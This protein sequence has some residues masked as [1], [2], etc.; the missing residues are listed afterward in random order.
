MTS[1][2]RDAPSRLMMNT[3]GNGQTLAFKKDGE[4]AGVVAFGINLRSVVVDG[5]TYTNAQGATR[6]VKEIE[7]ALIMQEGERFL[8]MLSMVTGGKNLVLPVTDNG[9]ISFSTKHTTVDEDGDEEPGSMSRSLISSLST[10]LM[11]I[12][13][14]KLAAGFLKKGNS[15][16]LSR[17]VVHADIQRRAR[18]ATETGDLN[19][20]FL[21]V[22]FVD[23]SSQF[24]FS[25]L[26]NT[27][28]EMNANFG[29]SSSIP[30]IF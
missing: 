4:L 7:I 28:G 13:E 14:G 24:Q 23:I 25:T 26:L 16:V 1:P 10:T 20:S 29:R 18:E 8:A 15:K 11:N 30:R 22:V 19:L 6:L 3:H 21:T 5:R 17:K 12:S 9:G 2:S 27:L